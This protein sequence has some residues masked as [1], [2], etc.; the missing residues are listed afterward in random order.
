[1]PYSQGPWGEMKVYALISDDGG[2]SWRYGSV[3]PNTD[4]AQA[5][6]V[7]MAELESGDIYLNARSCDGSH[8]RLWATSND[9]GESWSEL[10]NAPDLLDPQCHAS[11]C[12]FDAGDE[13]YY[14]LY[15]GPLHT[16]RRK[17]GCLMR[18]LDG[19]QSWQNL[20][21]IYD[22]FFAY[23]DL[24]QVDAQSIGVLFERDYYERVS[25]RIV[26]F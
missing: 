26:H 18:S 3:A 17:N 6:E 9:G 8:R 19:G 5:N 11:V 4:G 21:T 7:Q 13:R 1:M 10:Q 22:D 24:A 16:S 14:L 15:C 23:S 25:F 2:R 20:L 12:T